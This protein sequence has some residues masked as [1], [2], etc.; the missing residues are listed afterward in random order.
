MAVSDAAGVGALQTDMPTVSWVGL[1]SIHIQEASVP[2][3]G[4]A[5]CPRV[6]RNSPSKGTVCPG[7]GCISRLSLIHI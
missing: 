2:S 4:G 3:M 6:G 5:S 7:W 1:S